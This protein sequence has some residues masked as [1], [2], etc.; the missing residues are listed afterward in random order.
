MSLASQSEGSPGVTATPAGRLL[1]IFGN[2]LFPVERL[3]RF[4]DVPVFMA[5]DTGLCTYVRHHRQKLAL[6][7]SAMRS[8]RDDLLERGFG[9]HYHELGDAA[10]LC[11]ED[12]L[13]GTCRATG[14]GELLHFEIEDKFMEERFA[15]FARRNALRQTVLPSPMFLCDRGAF[16]DYVRR[17]AN[18]RMADFY[19]EMEEKGE[20]PKGFL[21][22]VEAAR[23]H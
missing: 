19:R 13:L 4:R 15:R 16:A 18:V 23:V 7:L 21:A 11:Y 6:F 5:E 12:K 8:Y 3:D 20:L 14:C 1:I 10:E 2:Q 22:A 17:A 9:V